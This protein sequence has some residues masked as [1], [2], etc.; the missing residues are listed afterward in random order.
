MHFKKI[1]Q[2]ND[3]LFKLE[4]LFQ[5]NGFLANR[6]LLPIQVLYL[7][8]TVYFIHDYKYIFSFSDALTFKD[9]SQIPR[10]LPYLVEYLYYFVLLLFQ[11]PGNL[12]TSLPSGK[13]HNRG[14][15]EGELICSFQ[16]ISLFSKFLFSKF[17]FILFGTNNKYAI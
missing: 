6:P 9:N 8:Q 17:L 4:K 13:I 15:T 5:F 1:F 2:L 14:G 11:I 10:N 3:F 7:P 12:P 16:L